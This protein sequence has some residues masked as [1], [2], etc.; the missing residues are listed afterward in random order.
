MQAQSNSARSFL[1]IAALGGESE[2]SPQR[3]KLVDLAARASMLVDHIDAWL[4]SQR[5]LI[6]GRT[7][8]LVPVLRLY[9]RFIKNNTRLDGAAF[10][11]AAAQVGL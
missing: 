6:N 5:S 2:L 9:Y 7:K 1:R 11:K 4:L 3:L 8:T 10:D